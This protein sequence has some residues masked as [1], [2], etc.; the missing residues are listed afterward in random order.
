M[1]VQF[2]IA[3]AGAILLIAILWCVLVRIAQLR[4]P[5][6]DF[7]AAFEDLLLQGRPQDTAHLA[8]SERIA[9]KIQCSLRELIWS[10]LFGRKENA[11]SGLPLPNMQN[12]RW[13]ASRRTSK[14]VRKLRTAV[15]APPKVAHMMIKKRNSDSS[16]GLAIAGPVARYALN[17]RADEREFHW[18]AR[19]NY[20][21]EKLQQQLEAATKRARLRYWLHEKPAVR[22]KPSTSQPVTP[23][24]FATLFGAGSPRTYHDATAQDRSSL[25]TTLPPEVRIIPYEHIVHADLSS[26]PA[27]GNE[28][29]PVQLRLIEKISDYR[30]AWLVPDI[31]P[32]SL[33]RLFGT[34]QQHHEIL[35][36]DFYHSQALWGNG[37]F[38]SLVRIRDMGVETCLSRKAMSLLR[39]LWTP[40]GRVSGSLRHC[41]R[42]KWASELQDPSIEVERAV[43]YLARYL[44]WKRAMWRECRRLMGVWGISAAD[45]CAR[46]RVRAVGM[47]LSS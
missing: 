6:V 16:H 27:I 46:G 2:W 9:I 40:K 22:G 14:Y 5:Q 29:P 20:D 11:D 34:L 30:I 1:E 37:E 18:R 39:E 35:L 24:S 23:A 43:W 25:F 15:S 32:P 19:I 12:C 38:R 21:M 17:V 3:A 8:Y 47:R 33:L 13:S 10:W 4:R 36:E 7:R 31:S 41:D 44:G 26:N 42:V 28:I 45:T